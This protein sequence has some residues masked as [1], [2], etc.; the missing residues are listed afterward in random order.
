MI[1]MIQWI[2]TRDGML[3]IYHVRCCGCGA[4][5]RTTEP[6]RNAL[7]PE[8]WISEWEKG[9]PSESFEPRALLDGWISP[10]TGRPPDFSRM[11][12][13]TYRCFGCGGLCPSDSSECGCG[14]EMVKV[15]RWPR[16]VYERMGGA[17][18]DWWAARR[19]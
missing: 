13:G 2:P 11:V 7:C 10:A 14:G 15:S 8:C 3:P 17:Q 6:L 9:I 12:W 18:D 16:D 1:L 19:S 5:F 4:S